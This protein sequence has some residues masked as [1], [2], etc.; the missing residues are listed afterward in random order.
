MACQ[1]CQLPTPK[2]LCEVCQYVTETEPSAPPPAC[3]HC[4]API[5]GLRSRQMYC[6]L[7]QEL[8]EI[9]QNNPWFHYAHAE[10]DQENL[11]LAKRKRDLLR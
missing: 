1:F 6:R 7:C 5:A 10:W 2:A 11:L 8:L 9:V 4:R 3:Q